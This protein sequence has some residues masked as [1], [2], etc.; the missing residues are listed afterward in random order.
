MRKS[1]TARGAILE[2]FQKHEGGPLRVC[3]VV[4]WVQ[5]N[6]PNRWKDISTS[7]AD[8]AIN[9]PVS[10]PY[11][12]QDRFLIRLSR[13]VYELSSACVRQE[14]AS[15]AESDL[16]ASEDACCAC[17]MQNGDAPEEVWIDG[18][19]SVFSSRH[20]KDWKRKLSKAIGE[21]AHNTREHGGLDVW[22]QLESTKR[23]GNYLDLDNLCEPLFSVLVNEKGYFGGKRP[24]IKWWKA[25]KSVRHPFG[26]G[27]H[28]GMSPVSP[29]PASLVVFEGVYTGASPRSAQDNEISRWIA[30]HA[31]RHQ[32]DQDTSYE[33]LIRFGSDTI[34]IGDI[35][36]GPVKSVVDNLY[37]VIGGTRRAPEDWRVDHLFVSKGYP[38]LS[39]DQVMILIKALVFTPPTLQE[40]LLEYET[41]LSK[42][43]PGHHKAFHQSTKSDPEST[44]AEAAIFYMFRWMGFAVDI[45][46]KTGT[47][48]V[49]FRCKKNRQEFV[50]EVTSIKSDTVTRKSGW[51]DRV[52]NGGFA[53]NMITHALLFKAIDKTPQMSNL[54]CPRVLV[55]TTEHIGAGALMGPHAAR[56]LMTGDTH[57]Q[58]KVNVSDPDPKVATQLSNSVFFRSKDGKIESCR[59]SISAILLTGIDSSACHVLGLL[60]PD[61]E[62]KFPAEY[63]PTVPFLTL[64]HWPPRKRR[65]ELRWDI[66]SVECKTAP[67]WPR[68]VGLFSTSGLGHSANSG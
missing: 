1:I 42:E 33:V 62:K 13:G 45:E 37:P 22:F 67:H 56:S 8:L 47:G 23:Q 53:F 61:P 51:P 27:F 66:S 64:C 50:A 44:R 31:Q 55:V 10:S 19:A 60:H 52:F 20:E 57:V 68:L 5:D 36:T 34:N 3:E 21:P 18:R 17:A 65:I 6:Y 38:G 12:K 30:E 58:L 59:R 40:T 29:H 43:Y 26:C 14:K 24:N 7:V 39:D 46:E 25:S 4:E 9:G 63:L 15:P 16:R 11:P 35:A 48:G 2:C 28:I 49:D 54:P 32:W 41:F